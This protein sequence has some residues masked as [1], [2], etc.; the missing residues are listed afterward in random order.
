MLL[1]AGTYDIGPD[2]GTVTVRTYR[3][4]MAAKIGHDLVMTVAQW[5]GSV[6]IDPDTPSNSSVSVS[7][8]TG[9]F[10][11]LS[12]TGGAKP[13]S[14]KD[15]K[16]ILNNIAGKVLHTD[17]HP[18]ITFTSE[19]VDASAE[20]RVGV[21]GKLTIAGTTRPVHLELTL[22]Q[23][24]GGVRASGTLPVKQ[25]EF[26]IKPFTALMGALKVKDDM[27]IDVEAALT[28]L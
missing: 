24:S 16:D 10:Q 3:E 1:P 23:T 22:E 27:E 20:N 19:R 12:G 7:F 8:D 26:G 18:Q 5:K 15:R 17:K 21:D 6:T 13:L 14:D 9:T 2:N 4:G 28:A 25:T 11:V